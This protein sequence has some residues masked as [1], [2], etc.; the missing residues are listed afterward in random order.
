M[1]NQTSKVM[2]NVM[3]QEDFPFRIAATFV[4][5]YSNYSEYATLYDVKNHHY[6]NGCLKK[7]FPSQRR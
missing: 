6:F 1:E 4:K 5:D 2:R 3:Q 7:I